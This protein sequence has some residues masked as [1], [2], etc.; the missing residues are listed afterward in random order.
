M[1]NVL[2]YNDTTNQM[3][4]YP[5]D[6][7]DPMPYIT[8][9]T[10]TVRE[11]RSRSASN[12][13]WTDRRTMLAWNRT[14][15]AW[16]QPIYVGFAFRRIGEGGHADQSQHYAG[17]AFD[18]GQN[19]SVAQRNDLRRVA[20]EIGVWSYVEPG[21]LTPTWVHFDNRLS[22]PACAAGYPALQQGDRGV[23]VCTLQ[24]A[25][26]TAGIPGVGVDGVFGP[27]TRQ[28]V[29]TFQSENGLST[30]GT[31]GCATWTQLTKMTNGYFRTIGDIPPQYRLE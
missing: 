16:G 2:L 20:A 18:V 17:T 29:V 3:E 4:R 19:L 25:L 5:L 22:P 24:D 1:I 26:I 6:L 10:L 28:A 11:F 15:E 12:L 31:V 27:L 14:R 8:G 21:H 23:Y 9:R 30:D 7:S 13:I